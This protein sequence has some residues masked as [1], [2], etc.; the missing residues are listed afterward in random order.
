MLLKEKMLNST[1]LYSFGNNNALYKDQFYNSY[2]LFKS[3]EKAQDYIT[4]FGMGKQDIYKV[5]LDEINLFSRNK[6]NDASKAGRYYRI[7]SFKKGFHE[8]LEE[9]GFEG[10]V[11]LEDD[12]KDIKET[13]YIIDN[14]K[15]IKLFDLNKLTFIS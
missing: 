4:N 6:K 14:F 1:E 10:V 11:E 12:E 9:M 15:I 5:K 3:K 2:L 8:A 7:N 13:R